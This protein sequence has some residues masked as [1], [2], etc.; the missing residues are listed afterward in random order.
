MPVGDY[1][2]GRVGLLRRIMRKALLSRAAVLALGLELS[3]LSLLVMTPTQAFADIIPIPEATISLLAIAVPTPGGFCVAAPS[4][5]QC[6]GSAAS[7]EIFYPSGVE[8]DE[9]FPAGSYDG[10]APEAGAYATA[11][12][13]ILPDAGV[14]VGGGGTEPDSFPDGQGA[15]ESLA[16]LTYF[17]ELSGPDSTV[18]LD[19]SAIVDYQGAGNALSGYVEITNTG[20]SIQLL[21]VATGSGSGD[22]TAFW[23]YA[24]LSATSN[25]LYEVQLAAGF[26]CGDVGGIAEPCEAETNSLFIDPVITIDPGFANANDFTLGFSPGVG[27]SFPVPEPS[28][29]ML[30]GSALVGFAG[31]RKRGL[32][33]MA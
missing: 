19:F 23:N 17:F 3:A 18:P 16:E 31:I 22:Y 9:S 4:P 1:Q 30:L 29:L 12:A 14:Y 20:T 7:G 15:V 25:V 26:A 2:I 33:L 11:G 24:P 10:Y 32:S 8:V 21:G 27:D 28:S 13:F 5:D 6:E